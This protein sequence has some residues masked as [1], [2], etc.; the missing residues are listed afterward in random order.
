MIK[1]KIGHSDGCISA[2]VE[3]QRKA[4]QALSESDQKVLS[5]IDSLFELLS[6]DGKDFLQ[7]YYT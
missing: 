5:E 1:R 6:E 3:K 4:R 2:F 7:E